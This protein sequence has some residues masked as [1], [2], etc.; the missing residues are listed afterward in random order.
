MFGVYLRG[1]LA[2]LFTH[3]PA[4]ELTDRIVALEDLWGAELEM[5]LREANGT[6]ERIGCLESALLARMVEGPKTRLDVA[7]LAAWVLRRRGRLTVERMADAAGVSRQHLTRAFRESVG[8]TPKLYCRLARFRAGL[9]HTG[10]DWADVA[11]ELGY[12]D[13]SHMIAEYREFSGLTPGTLTTQRYFH[14]FL[15]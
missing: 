1:A 10:G 6:A 2:P 15:T 3:V 5:R 8:V 7:G 14:P 12:A 13:Q 4:C 9:A 11:L